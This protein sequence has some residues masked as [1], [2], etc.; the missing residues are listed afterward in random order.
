MAYRELGVIE[1]R[2]VWRRYS[3]GEGVRAIARGTGVDRKTI[4]NYVAAAAAVGLQRGAPPP[5]DEQL[6]AFV[7]GPRGIPAGW[8]AALPERLG[9]YQAQIQAW[10]AEGLRLTKIRPAA[11]RPACLAGG[12]LLRARAAQLA[13]LGRPDRG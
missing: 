7:R 12:Q 8:P 3:A 13:R 1:L 9:P 2:E 10:L 11:P 6:T 5:M 4:A